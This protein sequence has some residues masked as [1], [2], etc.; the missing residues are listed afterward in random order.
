[1]KE[2]STHLISLVNSL[3]HNSPESPV[4]STTH[5]KIQWIPFNSANMQDSPSSFSPWTLQVT[6]KHVVWISKWLLHYDDTSF[7]H[8]SD[9]KCLPSFMLCINP[10]NRNRLCRWLAGHVANE[11][12]TARKGN[13]LN[14][15]E[16]NFSS[17]CG[18]FILLFII[19]LYFTIT[20]YCS[21]FKYLELN[22]YRYSKSA[23]G[24]IC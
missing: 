6:S 15:K 8:L 23:A 18:A 14:L 2:N 24:C 10:A 1:M 7:G 9:R 12:V 17:C 22:L 21:M 13:F 5:C 11:N 16:G 19:Y 3:I 4:P 20:N